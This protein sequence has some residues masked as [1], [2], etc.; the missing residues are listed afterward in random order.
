MRVEEEHAFDDA[1]A[2]ILNVRDENEDL[3][4]INKIIESCNNE[5]ITAPPSGASLISRSSTFPM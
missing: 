1:D 5:D 2:D 3:L 4:Q